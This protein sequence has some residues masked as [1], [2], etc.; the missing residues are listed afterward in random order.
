MYELFNFFHT[1]FRFICGIALSLSHWYGMP[2]L[3]YNEV[4]CKHGSF[5][6]HSDC[7]CTYA[8]LSNQ[9]SRVVI[10]FNTYLITSL[11]L[12][13][14][15]ILCSLLFH[16]NLKI[17]FLSFINNYFGT[18]IVITLINLERITISHYCHLA[19]EH[20]MS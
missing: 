20:D 6:Q 5:S 14:L 16:K 15:Y 17:T 9:S 13:I 4:P 7:F 19:H 1:S 18:L 2:I 10:R 8:T 11:L 12:S 3:S